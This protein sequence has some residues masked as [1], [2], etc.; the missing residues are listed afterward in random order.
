MD[1]RIEVN[2]GHSV[3]CNASETRKGKRNGFWGR[4]SDL[5]CKSGATSA[6]FFAKLLTRLVSKPQLRLFKH[7]SEQYFYYAFLIALLRLLIPIIA[8]SVV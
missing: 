2:A 7:I 5:E 1:D 4:K 3:D 8:S 6:L